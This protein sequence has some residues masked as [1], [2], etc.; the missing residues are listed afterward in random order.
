MLSYQQKIAGSTYKKNS[1]TQ[2]ITSLEST[3]SICPAAEIG[4]L[5]HKSEHFIHHHRVIDRR[6]ASLFGHVNSL[7]LVRRFLPLPGFFL[8]YLRVNTCQSLLIHNITD[9]E[10][11]TITSLTETPATNSLSPW[12]P[13]FL[14]HVPLPSS[15][16]M[17]ECHFP[18]CHSPT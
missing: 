17:L 6:I 11:F 1:S 12:F 4:R 3:R 18:S 7:F 10:W 14:T 16:H 2:E 9:V 15:H 8:R 13:T 5:I